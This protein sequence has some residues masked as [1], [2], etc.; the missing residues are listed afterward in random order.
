MK[1]FAHENFRNSIF[2]FRYFLHDSGNHNANRHNTIFIETPL[3][4]ADTREVRRTIRGM[5]SK[6]SARIADSVI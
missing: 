3:V 4:S 1:G 5:Y 6:Q 2:D